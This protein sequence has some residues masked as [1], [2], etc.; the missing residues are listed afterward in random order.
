M[1]ALGMTDYVAT[2]AQLADR[3]MT[4]TRIITSANA[5]APDVAQQIRDAHDAGLKV[6]LT[7]GGI[8]TADRRP[9]FKRS[10]RFVQR[11]PRVEYVSIDNEADLD[12]VSACHLREG[13]RKGRR[14]FGSRWIDFEFSPHRP[15]TYLQAMANRCRALPTKL[16]VAIHPYQSTDPLAPPPRNDPWQEGGIGRLGWGKRW[17]KRNVGVD[18]TWLPTEFGYAT[19]IGETDTGLTD[20]D[21][22][23]MWPRALKRF[24]QLGVPFA[25]GYVADGPTWRSAPLPA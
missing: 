10:I 16:K 14:V 1:I 4:W 2:P 24:D 21:A 20:E 19:R 3:G 18:V 6:V 15:L 7:V 22:A 23:R 25:I 17:L 12:G 8:G 9:N 13:S 11:L 5:Q